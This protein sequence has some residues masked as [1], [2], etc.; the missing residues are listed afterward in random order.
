M[1]MEGVG[2]GFAT[3][4][5]T[6]SGTTVEATKPVVKDTSINTN[7]DKYLATVADKKISQM[8][9]EE[10]RDLPIADKVIIQAIERANKAISGANREFR[11]AIHDKTKQ[12][13]IKVIDSDTK[14]VIRE[15]PPEKTL[16]MVAKMWEMAGIVVDE[17]R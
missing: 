4:P 16:D 12:I 3:I 13:M 2:S 5:S 6:V 1:K 10:K 15:I 7:A 11:F 14:E 9:N 8:S 17:K